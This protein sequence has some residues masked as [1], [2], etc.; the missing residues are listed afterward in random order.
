[1]QCDS[2]QLHDRLIS[3][4]LDITDAEEAYLFVVDPNT[5][6]LHLRKASNLLAIDGIIR[7]PEDSGI[8]GLTARQNCTQS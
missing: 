3:V 6:F 2:E 1:M 4:A 5:S 7:R 8:L